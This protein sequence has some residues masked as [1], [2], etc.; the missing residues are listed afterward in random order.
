MIRVRLSAAVLVT[1]LCLALLACGQQDDQAKEGQ[2]APPEEA[3]AQCADRIQG[4]IETDTDY[5]QMYW[6]QESPF[7][8]V[9]AA[10]P[11]V[12]IPALDQASRA[13]VA[14]TICEFQSS[15][16]VAQLDGT[17]KREL[18]LVDEQGE[19]TGLRYELMITG[20]ELS[21]TQLKSV[22]LEADSRLGDTA[23]ER[24]IHTETAGSESGT[25]GINA[26]ITGDNGLRRLAAL[27]SRQLESRL[28]DQVRNAGLLPAASNFDNFM[29]GS[30]QLVLLF[31]PGQA[32]PEDR[33]VLQVALPLATLSEN[34]NPDYFSAGELRGGE[35]IFA[36]LEVSRSGM[37]LT[38][39]GSLDTYVVESLSSDLES[40]YEAARSEPADSDKPL[41]VA[42]EA[43]LEA[44]QAGSE[45]AE[46]NY[47]GTARI[48]KLEGIGESS[49]CAAPEP[50]E[51]TPA[52]ADQPNRG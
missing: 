10:W 15:Y 24:L 23:L 30:R 51:N 40:A 20:E 17:L 32:A 50:F 39:C 11:A 6:Q 2:T 41:H 13:W 16:P 49:S 34:L 29:I 42:V 14:Q 21:S 1:S 3:V 52:G 12:E 31:P 28:G 19:P 38:P 35:L 22:L 5:G 4:E 47:A 18:G 46:L 45:L 8:V 7:Q 27:A 25:V 44:A 26:L 37:T 36:L 43:T 9:R 48:F 33:G